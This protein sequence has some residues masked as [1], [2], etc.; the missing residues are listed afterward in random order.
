MAYARKGY[1]LKWRGNAHG[2]RSSAPPKVVLCKGC[3][4]E[5]PLLDFLNNA[6]RNKS[7][8]TRR[9]KLCKTCR[10]QAAC[11]EATRAWSWASAVSKSALMSAAGTGTVVGDITAQS[12]AAIASLQHG[13]CA[14]TGVELLLPSG[15]KQAQTL[16]TWAKNSKS[17]AED[18]ARLPVLVRLVSAEPL[19][20]GN[21]ALVARA[22]EMTVHFAS[23]LQGVRNIIASGSDV[24]LFTREQI[25][26]TWRLM[27]LEAIKDC[28]EINYDEI[29]DRSAYG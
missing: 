20:P 10:D 9:L 4:T 8:R 29:E 21:M 19:G 2:A 27:E 18:M 23:N 16:D 3:N 6:A 28:E 11:I 12:V 5:R 14:L 24:V 25:A 26:K 13:L 17:T 1:P 15:L 22:V 7:K